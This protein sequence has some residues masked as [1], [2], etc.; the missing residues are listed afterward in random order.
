MMLLMVSTI[1]ASLALGVAIAHGLCS[2]LFA[3]ARLHV[4]AQHPG[5]LPMQTKIANP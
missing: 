2:A 5:Q 4:R 1:L 3:M